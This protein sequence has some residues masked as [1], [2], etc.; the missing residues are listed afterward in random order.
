[1]IN[2]KQ[3]FVVE[4]HQSWQPNEEV[5]LNYSPRSNW[6]LM[7]VYGFTLPNNKFNNV[8][9]NLFIESDDPHRSWKEFQ[10]LQSQLLT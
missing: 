5:F 7:R 2:N 8:P 4:T 9:L 3:E 6:E 10:L 1:M